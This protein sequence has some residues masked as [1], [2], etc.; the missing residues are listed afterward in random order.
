M[1]YEHKE[2]KG[3]KRGRKAEK[4]RYGQTGA[5]ATHTLDLHLLPTKPKKK[6]RRSK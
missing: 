4:K 5:G 1:D 3:E 6:N 2:T